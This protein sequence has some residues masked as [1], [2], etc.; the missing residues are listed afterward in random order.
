[1]SVKQKLIKGVN[2][3][4]RKGYWFNNEFLPE[5]NKFWY[6]NTFNTDVMNVGS[7][8]ACFAFNYDG[9]N[10]KGANFALR[11]NPQWADLAVLKCYFS[12]LNPKK[13]T[14][15]IPLCPFTALSA[16]YENVEDFHYSVLR[17]P[18]MPTF[19]YQQQV[20]ANNM[21]ERTFKYYTICGFLKDIKHMCFSRESKV[22]SEEQLLSDANSVFDSWMSEFSL[23]DFEAPLSGLNKD[24]IKEAGR[25]LNETIAFCKARNIAPAIII[26]PVYH[27][28]ADKFTE[29]GNQILF[30]S[31]LNQVV[32]KN[33]PV[34]DYF[35]D[36]EFCEDKRL[37]RNSF[38][39]NKTGARLFTKRV[40]TDLN[41]I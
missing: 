29:K 4:I 13:S 23:R 6:Y 2:K 9:L 30:D 32:D 26:P 35:R 16:L 7:T 41:L 11:R 20:R 40:L 3:I 27:T 38:L 22:L 25:L 8:N 10:I 37:F 18:V 21:R 19:Y 17:P 1:M 12:Y 36:K 15:L 24:S 39:L 34:L 28:L 5:C 33:I 31:I 14:V